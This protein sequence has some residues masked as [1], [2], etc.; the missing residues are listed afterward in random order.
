P[1]SGEKP[2]SIVPAAGTEMGAAGAAL[3]PAAP[4]PTVADPDAAG[5]ACACAGKGDVNAKPV[6]QTA[7]NRDKANEAF[8]AIIREKAAAA[9]LPPKLPTV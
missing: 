9:S 4:E 5:L 8:T 2:T 1:W 7:T 6:A 3:A